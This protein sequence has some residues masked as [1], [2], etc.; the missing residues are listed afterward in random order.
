M[1]KWLVGL[2]LVLLLVAHQDYW[3]WD[4]YELVYGFLPYNMAWHM[5]L[6]LV[7]ALA[8]IVVCIWFWPQDSHQGNPG[9]SP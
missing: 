6:S 7:T 4:R 1:K 5:G 8:W 3:Q 9:G 2:I